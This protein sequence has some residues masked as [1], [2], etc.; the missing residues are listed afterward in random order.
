M[1]NVCS[2]SVG[3]EY[4]EFL[5]SSWYDKEGKI[6][7]IKSMIETINASGLVNISLLPPGSDMYDFSLRI[8]GTKH[9]NEKPFYTNSTELDTI[10]EIVQGMSILT[11]I[12]V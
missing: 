10:Y 12:I 5:E 7:E 11:A 3:E 4:Q 2:N 6:G 9:Y 1:N 8:Y